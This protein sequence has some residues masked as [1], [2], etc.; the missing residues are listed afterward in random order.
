[1]KR[2]GIINASLIFMLIKLSLPILYH[3]WQTAH[4]K[5]KTEAQQ[6]ST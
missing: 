3:N 6:D 5:D 1:M 2:I 4:I